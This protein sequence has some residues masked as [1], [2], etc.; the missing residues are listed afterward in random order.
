MRGGY[1]GLT[2]LLRA[3]QATA[4]TGAM[5]L[6]PQ[7]TM[8]KTAPS[9]VVA[10]CPWT[11]LLNAGAVPR[12]LCACCERSGKVSQEDEAQSKHQGGTDPGRC[13]GSEDNCCGWGGEHRRAPP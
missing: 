8:F 10:C 2:R 13:I 5:T 4:M 9:T 3:R 1:A 7:F 6:Q 11:D 12:F